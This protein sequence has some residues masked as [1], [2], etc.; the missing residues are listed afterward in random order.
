MG[1]IF[2]ERQNHHHVIQEKSG[3]VL[4]S[5]NIKFLQSLGFKVR[6]YENDGHRKGSSIRRNRY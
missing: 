1:L 3:E 6:R 5:G 4:T 2:N